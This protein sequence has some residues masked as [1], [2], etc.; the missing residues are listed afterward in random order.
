MQMNILSKMAIYYSIT[1]C[2]DFCINSHLNMPYMQGE[3][4]IVMNVGSL[5][6]LKE[7]KSLKTLMIIIF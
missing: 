7:K 4:K 6:I 2:Q 1:K 3:R 5:K